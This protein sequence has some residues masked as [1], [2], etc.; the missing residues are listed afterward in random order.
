MAQ[1]FTVR[2]TGG[3]ELE[4]A[5][6]ELGSLRRVKGAITRAEKRAIEPVAAEA[7]R[8]APRGKTG[9]LAGGVTVARV[10]R[11]QGASADEITHAVGVTGAHRFLAHLF[12]FGFT[13]R[14]VHYPAR[15]FLRPAWDGGKQGVLSDFSGALWGIVQ[16]A[17][18]RA[19]RRRA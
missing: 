1:T 6:R 12:E 19:R 18:R 17:A 5:L 13:R 3:R 2:V 16:R 11:R 9:L 4:A 7:A 15:P 8:R 14:G 10:T